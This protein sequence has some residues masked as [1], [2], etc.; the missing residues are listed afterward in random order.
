MD[1]LISPINV[2]ISSEF[3]NADN[4]LLVLIFYLTSDCTYDMC[5]CF[6]V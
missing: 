3:I 6:S 4:E 5:D 1:V 2:V